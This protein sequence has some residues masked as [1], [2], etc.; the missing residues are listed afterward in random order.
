M[1]MISPRRAL[2]P[3]L[4]HRLHHS[5]G[6]FRKHRQQMYLPCAGREIERCATRHWAIA[7]RHIHWSPIPPP[8]ALRAPRDAGC[9]LEKLVSIASTLIFLSPLTQ[10]PPHAVYADHHGQV[11]GVASLVSCVPLADTAELN[12][13]ILLRS[14]ASPLRAP[15]P[16][17]TIQGTRRTGASRFENYAPRGRVL[18]RP[19]G[20]K[21]VNS[22]SRLWSRDGGNR[23]T[24]SGARTR[25]APARCAPRPRGASTPFS[26]TF[27]EI[28]QLRKAAHK[29]ETVEVLQIEHNTDLSMLDIRVTIIAPD[30]PPSSTGLFGA[31]GG[32]NMTGLFAK[33]TLGCSPWWLANALPP[34]T[35][36]TTIIS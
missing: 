32:I 16:P 1:P 10:R 30:V 20:T 7:S 23:R 11:P 13:A 31:V 29:P 5:T 19:G 18:H 8:A 25:T 4:S 6:N 27:S 3:R 15:G 26:R 14:H 12:D 2:L 9:E 28:Q 36:V 24:P 22:T 35:K 33:L 21:L 34:G 17:P